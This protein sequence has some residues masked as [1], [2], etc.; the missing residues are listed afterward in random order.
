MKSIIVTGGDG[1]F[2]S[3]LKKNYYNKNIKFFNKK[4]LNILNQRSILKSIYKYKPKIIIHLAGLSR[5]MKIHDINPEKSIKLNIIGTSNLVIAC[6][7]FNIKLI[8]FSTSYIYPGKKGDYKETDAL[9][10]WNKYGWS[11]LGAEC[12]VQMYSNSLIL[13]LCMTEKPFIHKKAYANV[14]SNFIFHEDIVK[15]L[16]KLLNKK[17]VYNIGGKKQTIYNFAK[18]FNKNVKKIYSRGEFPLRQDMSLKKLY[19]VL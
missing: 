4:E 14:Y 12:A 15:I 1:R 16:I 8:Y 3:V 18:K 13:R 9:L 19:K 7:K 6:K 17:G 10:P 11:K 5:P 2:A